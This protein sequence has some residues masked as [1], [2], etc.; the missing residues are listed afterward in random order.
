MPAPKGNFAA[1]SNTS[2]LDTGRPSRRPSPLERPQGET[3]NV[4]NKP[5][6]DE[7]TMPTRVGDDAVTI[8]SSP[9]FRTLVWPSRQ[10]RPGDYQYSRIVL[11]NGA[12]QSKCHGDS[13]VRG[14]HHDYRKGPAHLIR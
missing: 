13:D 8:P 12:N 3:V 2:L 5:L 11:D 14:G 1:T 10:H 7:P 9:R 6:T 4:R